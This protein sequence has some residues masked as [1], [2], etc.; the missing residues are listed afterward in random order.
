MHYSIFYSIFTEYNKY[1][2]FCK[3][4]ARCRPSTCDGSFWCILRQKGGQGRAVGW[5]SHCLS[6]VSALRS[7]FHAP[8]SC[9]G[10]YRPHPN[11]SHRSA[12]TACGSL[13]GGRSSG[14]RYLLAR[15][16]AQTQT[17]AIIQLANSDPFVCLSSLM[18]RMSWRRDCL[19]PV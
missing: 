1:S 7:C 2:T 17:C 10:S 14:S 12:H 4:T 11:R 16:S 19:I 3:W 9:I 6:L 18:F 15:S 13:P 5:Y 8:S